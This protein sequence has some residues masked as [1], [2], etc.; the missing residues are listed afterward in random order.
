MAINSEEKIYNDLMNNIPSSTESGDT[1]LSAIALTNA[2]STPIDD[3]DNTYSGKL[4]NVI[5]QYLKERN[6]AYDSSQDK[7]YQSYRTE[8][9]KAAAAAR[10]RSRNTAN[11]LAGGFK[12]TY[13]D[14]VASEIYNNHIS[15]I[16]DASSTF[17]SLAEQDYQAEHE[18]NS[19]LLNIYNTLEDK[20]YSRHRDSLND[21]KNYINALANRYSTNKQSDMSVDNLNNDIYSTKLSGAMNNLSEQRAYNNQQY[22]YNTVSANQSAQNAQS[23]A[24]NAKKIQ[25]EK[26]YNTYEK[27]K[28]AIKSNEEAQA[29]EDKRRLK[30]VSD[31][32]IKAYNLSNANYKFQLGQ[33]A[34]GYYNGYITLDEMDYI[35]EK[36]NVS[37]DDLADAIDII[38]ANNGG[39][40]NSRGKTKYGYVNSR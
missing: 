16:S 11:Q 33:L 31:K 21:Y 6:F 12:P 20:D 22:L 27:N 32:F 34:Q 29:K 3:Y 15:N 24:E 23:E 40:T 17:K 14:T 13:S 37:T 30:R 25:Y 2:E 10:E 7:A 39:L 19:N 35:A 26:D 9:A 4:D 5:N 8:Y 1:K 38:E 18:K 28:S 36:L